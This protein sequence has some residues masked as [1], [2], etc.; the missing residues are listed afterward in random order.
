M[1]HSRLVLAALTVLLLGTWATFAF[2]C[3]SKTKVTKAAASTAV[4][5][6][7]SS[8]VCTPAMAA[9]CTP[10]MAA[11]CKAKGAT[12][13]AASASASGCAAHKAS[14]ATASMTSGCGSR[15]SATA[16]TAAAPARSVDAVTAGAGCGSHGATSAVTAAAPSAK[17][18]DAVVAGAGGSCSGHGASKSA[19]AKTSDCDGCA[20][21]AFCE[22]EAKSMGATVQVVPLKNG[23]MYVYTAIDPGKVHAVQAS[24]ERRSEHM[25]TLLSAGDKA[26]L[27]PTCKSVRGAIASG[28]LSREL[29]NIEGGCLT[30]MTSND[31]ATLA[32]IFTMAG[33][34]SPASA[35]S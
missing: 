32:Q 5:A 28:K 12:A 29:V 10:E 33:I 15:T 16:V 17:G 24:M 13:R 31:P 11:A 18:V 9:Q 35:K 2:A 14:A 6:S 30:L 22:G 20:D 19:K 27:C 34:K 1:K 23:V 4:T 3:E 25:A 21:M 8:A 7:N 26:H